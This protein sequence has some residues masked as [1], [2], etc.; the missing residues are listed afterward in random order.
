MHFLSLCLEVLNGFRPVTHLRPL[1]APTEFSAV[2]EQV[3]RALDRIPRGSGRPRVRLRE[4]RVCEPLPGIAEL[5][6]VLGHGDRAW[7]MALRLE[8]RPTGW[9]CTF[10]QV[11]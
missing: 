4:L 10:A 1:T 11:V 6:A 3:G 8:R 2:T 7:A 9:L 5:A